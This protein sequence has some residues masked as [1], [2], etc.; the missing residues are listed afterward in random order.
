VI[1]SRSLFFSWLMRLEQSPLFLQ[2]TPRHQLPSDA[3]NTTRAPRSSR[4]CIYARKR[5]LD[6]T[7]HLHCACMDELRTSDLEIRGREPFECPGNF[8]RALTMDAGPSDLNPADR[9]R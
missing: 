4:T 7:L 5:G 3:G 8:F 9:N 2:L 1:T 6:G